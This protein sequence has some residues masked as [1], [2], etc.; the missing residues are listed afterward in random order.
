[1]AVMAIND[2]SRAA[3]VPL[4]Y[5]IEGQ[6]TV[7]RFGMSIREPVSSSLYENEATHLRKTNKTSMV[8]RLY[9]GNRQMRRCRHRWRS[10]TAWY[11]SCQLSSRNTPDKSQAHM[12]RHKIAC[13]A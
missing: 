1:M 9:R 7:A 11:A 2:S 13:A 8:S 5:K 10:S 12:L 3:L 6:M 4:A